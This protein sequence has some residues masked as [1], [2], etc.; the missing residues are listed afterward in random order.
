[1]SAKK[2][3]LLWGLAA[4]AVSLVAI[5]AA[6]QDRPRLIVFLQSQVRA[7]A[8][9]AMLA[10][11]MPMV[12]VIVC[13]RYR[14]FTKE[15][16]TSPEAALALPPVLRA[17]GLTLDLKAVRAGQE[18]EAYV[19]LSIGKAIEKERFPA[20]VVGAVDLLGRDGTSQFVATLLGLENPP[21]EIK[22][23]IKSEDLLPL[24]QFHSAQAV[25]LPEQEAARI[26]SLSKID[27][28]VTPLPTRVG[29]P[30]VSFRNEASKRLIEPLIIAWD[31]ETKSKLGVEAWH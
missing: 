29:L 13:G 10:R 9:E 30:A 21:P 1:V 3:W 18:T 12:D 20:L 28:K 31:A 22:Y 7:R 4:L 15:L 6:S 8:L 14:D 19:L 24:L 5:T 26:K 25:I 16:A 17:H 2:R 27:L 23:V 11:Q